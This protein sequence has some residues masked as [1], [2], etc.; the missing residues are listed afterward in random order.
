MWYDMVFLATRAD[1]R[2]KLKQK[3]K[4]N[5]HTLGLLILFTHHEAFINTNF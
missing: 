1:A 3:Y 5:K 2:N 4:K